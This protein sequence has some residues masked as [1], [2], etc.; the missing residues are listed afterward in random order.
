MNSPLG[1]SVGKSKRGSPSAAEIATLRRLLLATFPLSTTELDAFPTP[2][3]V[4]L[5]AG[6][7]FLR[8]GERAH[9]VATVYSGGLREYFVL[10]DGSERT[11][12]FNLPGD[13][14]G[15]LSDLLSDEPARA[16][17]VAE[18]PTVLLVTQWKNYAALVEASPGWQRFAKVI[19]EGL[20]RSKVQREYE[21]L[22]L[23]AAARYQL[24]LQRWPRLE[25]VFKQRHIASYVGITPV[26]LS[27]LRATLRKDKSRSKP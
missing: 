2:Q 21:L 8:A 27:R 16:W 6:S 19:A 9:E 13:F 5:P 7:P 10:A 3:R 14:A 22:A 18:V 4:E 11:K 20:Y 17:V 25:T 23:D 1:L 24:A 26:H 12:G 15:S